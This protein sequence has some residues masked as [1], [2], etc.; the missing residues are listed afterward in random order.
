[1][2]DEYEYSL[3]NEYKYSYYSFQELHKHMHC[4]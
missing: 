4:T 1:M 2:N 3:M